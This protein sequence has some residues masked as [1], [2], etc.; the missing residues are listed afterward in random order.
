MFYVNQW[1]RKAASSILTRRHTGSFH[2]AIG[3]RTCMEGIYTKQSHLLS[4]YVCVKVLLDCSQNVVLKTLS[5][6]V[7]DAKAMQILDGGYYLP[8]KLSDFI[9]FQFLTFT[10]MIHKI[11]SVRELK[12]KIIT[13]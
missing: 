3:L 4:I 12:H 1:N 11:A 7:H 13:L 10:N 8:Y 6:P 2:H 9:L 5:L